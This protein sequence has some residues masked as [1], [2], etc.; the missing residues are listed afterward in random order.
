MKA[1]AIRSYLV[2]A[3]AMGST[4]RP[5]ETPALAAHRSGYRLRSLAFFGRG[6]ARLSFIRA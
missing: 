6:R 5:A 2:I 1:P 3:D 4:G